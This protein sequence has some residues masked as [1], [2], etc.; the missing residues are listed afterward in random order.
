MS[1]RL[2]LTA[3][4]HYLIQ[5]YRK[6]KATE[7]AAGNVLVIGDTHCPA[8]K[9]GY[10]DFLLTV[11][12]RYKCST[13]VHIGDLVDHHAL[14]YH[15]QET[16]TP[17]AIHE[18]EDAVK[19]CKKLYKAFPKVK[20]CYGNHD[21][22]IGRKARS[23]GIPAKF[24]KPFHKIYEMPKGWQVANEWIIDGV[25]YFHGTGRSG[26]YMAFN[27]A[28]EDGINTVCGHTHT[29]GGSIH[30]DYKHGR[31]PLWSLQCGCGIDVDHAAMRY[32]SIYKGG[33]ALGCGVVAEAGA[34][35]I[36]VPMR[37]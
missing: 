19:Q 34:V 2:R 27:S 4:E 9:D 12:E 29:Y 1:Y 37:D 35:P 32:G 8:M 21:L 30:K 22:R 28:V 7:D 10:I 14:S 26:K 20:M 33:V 16:D 6:Q 24:I 36:F 31:E 23:M 13:V 11:K 15:E 3:D 17:A 18:W 5:S 25:R